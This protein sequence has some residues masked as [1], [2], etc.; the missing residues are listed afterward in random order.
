[1]ESNCRRQPF[2]GRALSTELPG[3]YLVGYIRAASMRQ[4]RTMCVRKVF[5]YN[6]DP[7]FPLT[8]FESVAAS[9]KFLLEQSKKFLLTSGRDPSWQHSQ[10]S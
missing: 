5:D 2:Q 8:L 4:V 9:E 7:E 6:N 1:M 10:L 3:Q